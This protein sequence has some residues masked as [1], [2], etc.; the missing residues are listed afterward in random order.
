[1][2]EILLSFKCKQCRLQKK[3][4]FAIYEPA[5]DWLIT[6]PEKNLVHIHYGN[7]THTDETNIGEAKFVKNFLFSLI[8]KY[9]HKIFFIMVDIPSADDS[10]FVPPESLKLYKEVLNNKQINQGVFYGGTRAFHTL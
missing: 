1:M 8:E 5:N 7:V 3:K 6:N 10:E 9:P 2:N 4:D